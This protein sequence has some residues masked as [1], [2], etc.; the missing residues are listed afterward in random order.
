MQGHELHPDSILDAE[1]IQPRP[2][3][4]RVRCTPFLPGTRCYTDAATTPD[5]DQQ[6]S[7][8]TGLGI[9]IINSEQGRPQD[10]NVYKS[11]NVGDLISPH[12]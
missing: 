12:V 7:R 4:F 9:F 6:S 8:P 1:D 2:P 10:H 3:F 11:Q 5:Q